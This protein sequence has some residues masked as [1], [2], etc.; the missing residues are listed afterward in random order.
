MRGVGM[1]VAGS[2][3]LGNLGLGCGIGAP[4][5][6]ATMLGII[7]FGRGI[8]ILLSANMFFIALTP[9]FIAHQ[10]ALGILS[11]RRQMYLEISPGAIPKTLRSRRIMTV[12][13]GQTLPSLGRAPIN[14]CVLT[15]QT[16]IR[17]T[18]PLA[19][20]AIYLRRRRSS[21]NRILITIKTPK[22]R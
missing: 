8:G 2:T 12:T 5:A 14:G 17:S 21:L 10:M 9:L 22:A 1:P 4:V 18:E 19:S 15:A 6:G 13:E 3:S 11:I 7:G 20:Q 16:A